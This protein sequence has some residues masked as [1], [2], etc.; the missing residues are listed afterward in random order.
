MMK[1]LKMQQRSC[2]QESK[3]KILLFIMSEVTETE[4]VL[5]PQEVKRIKDK[6][7]VIVCGFWKLMK[8]WTI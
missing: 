1:N 6:I 5:A 8:K 4:L 3:T 7:P 2:L